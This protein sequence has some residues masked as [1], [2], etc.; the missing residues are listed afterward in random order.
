M[1]AAGARA[2]PREPCAASASQVVREQKNKEYQ[3]RKAAKQAE[4][5]AWKKLQEEE[6]AKR[7]PWE[8]RPRA[9]PAPA[10]TRARPRPPPPPLPRS[11]PPRPSTRAPP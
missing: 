2:P 5:D 4:Y 8:A 1:R 7:D 11:L 9:P 3:E 6:E 10:P